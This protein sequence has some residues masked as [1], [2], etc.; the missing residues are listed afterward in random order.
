MY[1]W[2]RI[3]S[4]RYT[5]LHDIIRC[6]MAHSRGFVSFFILRPI[7]ELHRKTPKRLLF[8]KQKNSQLENLYV[9]ILTCADTSGSYSK[10][11]QLVY[12]I[13][14]TQGERIFW[15]KKRREMKRNHV[16]WSMLHLLLLFLQ[17]RMSFGFY[18]AINFAFIRFVYLHR[19]SINFLP[20]SLAACWYFTLTISMH[21]KL[22]QRIHRKR[23]FCMAAIISEN[24]HSQRLSTLKSFGK[25][26]K[27][28]STPERSKNKKTSKYFRN[29]F[30]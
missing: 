19:E 26:Y 1:I 3:A 6:Y 14:H 18:L 2:K 5:V 23:T 21:R 11:F 22:L 24:Q 7:E 25:M 20:V 8:A 4:L 28:S 17:I 12:L 9:F 29:W 10:R 30:K 13:G 27:F 15:T 16:G